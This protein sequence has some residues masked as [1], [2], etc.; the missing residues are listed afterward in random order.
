MADDDPPTKMGHDPK[1]AF[2]SARIFLLGHCV[3]ARQGD[4][5]VFITAAEWL[6]VNYGRLMRQLFLHQLGGQSLTVIEPTAQPFDDAATTAAISHFYR[7]FKAGELSGCRVCADSKMLGD[8][9]KWARHCIG[10]RLEAENRW[11]HLM[12]KQRPVHTG[13]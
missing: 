5:G 10:G 4:F 6:D 9:K 12:R 2:R 8:L 13:M 3:E 1:S 7:G 11:S